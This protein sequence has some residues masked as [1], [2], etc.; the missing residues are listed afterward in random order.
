MKLFYDWAKTLT[1]FFFIVNHFQ[2]EAKLNQNNNQTAIVKGIHKRSLFYPVLLYPYNAC[3]GILVAL[4]IPLNLPNNE[5]FVSYNFEANYN[6]PNQPG[7]SFPGIINRF[8]G[9]NPP[10]PKIDIDAGGTPDDII[11]ERS[12]VK[13]NNPTNTTTDIEAETEISVEK[14][15]TKD[16]VLMSRKGVYRVLESRLNA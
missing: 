4:A 14:R 9:L 12:F 2:S 7:E 1:V 10:N 16:S 5:V 3:S 6:M 15:D 8:Q 11:L 13:D